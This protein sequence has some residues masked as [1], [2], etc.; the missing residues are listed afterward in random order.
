[1][2]IA[3]FLVIS[4]VYKIAILILALFANSLRKMAEMCGNRIH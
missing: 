1:M 4:A 3:L 2:T